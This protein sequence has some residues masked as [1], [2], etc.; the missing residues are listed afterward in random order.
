MSEDQA[1][2]ALPEWMRDCIAAVPDSLVRAIVGDNR[3]SQSL[4]QSD[5]AA[6]AVKG[7][8]WVTAT[9]LGPRPA[10]EIELIDRLAEKFAG[11]PNSPV[12]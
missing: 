11:G 10:H 3:A 6:P 8:G 1:K 9:P 7:T 5:P 4:R 2:P 12:R